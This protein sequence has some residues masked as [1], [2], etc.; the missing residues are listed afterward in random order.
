METSTRGELGLYFIWRDG[1][2]KVG[3]KVK[4]EL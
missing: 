3:R 4:E 2:D 1:W